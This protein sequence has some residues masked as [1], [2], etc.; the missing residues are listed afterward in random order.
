MLMAFKSTKALRKAAT[1][2]IVL[3]L[4]FVMPS[5]PPH[6]F[7][8]PLSIHFIMQKFSGMLKQPDTWIPTFAKIFIIQDEETATVNLSFTL[9]YYY[10]R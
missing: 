2:S 9:F 6:L 8:T 10:G 1:P 3:N 5:Y 4:P 7:V